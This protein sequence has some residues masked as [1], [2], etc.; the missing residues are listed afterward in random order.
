MHSQKRVSGNQPLSTVSKHLL[1][2]LPLKICRTQLIL[3]QYLNA[4]W[5]SGAG[6]GFRS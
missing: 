1:L 3:L 4:P 2:D 6:D 5:I